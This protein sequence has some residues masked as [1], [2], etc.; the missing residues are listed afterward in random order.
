MHSNKMRD[1]SE[2]DDDMRYRKG[3]HQ[4]GRAMKAA[5]ETE[6]RQIPGRQ[7]CTRQ[8]GLTEGYSLLERK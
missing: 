2:L 8:E 3:E 5:L 1:Y 6:Q 4:P 7:L